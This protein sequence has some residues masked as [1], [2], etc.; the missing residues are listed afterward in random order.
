M[1]PP[2]TI[3]LSRGMVAIVDSQD[4]EVLSQFKWSVAKCGKK[5]YAKRLTPNKEGKKTIY[6]HRFIMG[7]GKADEI[8]HK[9]GDGLNN[10]RVNLRKATRSQNNANRKVHP[11][12]KCGHHG[13]VNN[14]RNKWYGKVKK[15]SKYYWTAGFDNPADAAYAR[16][17]LKI[18]LFGE[19]AA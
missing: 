15:D 11:K 16:A 18:Q 2:I 4:Y 12:N 19:F 6:M 5:W 13:V 17:A 10:T 3:R 1:I 9:D 8:D 7:V 14:G